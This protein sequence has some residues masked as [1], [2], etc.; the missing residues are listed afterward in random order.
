ME[1]GYS[2]SP[3]KREAKR[4]EV[5]GYIHKQCYLL[6]GMNVSSIHIGIPVTDLIDINIKL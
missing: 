2:T 6:A 4:S 1:P 5:A 3:G